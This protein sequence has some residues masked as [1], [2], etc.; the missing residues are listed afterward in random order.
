MENNREEVH[1]LQ[2]ETAKI[3]NF[4]RQKIG[5]LVL[6]QIGEH[7]LITQLYVTIFLKL[8]TTKTFG[9]AMKV[10]ESLTVLLT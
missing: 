5:L 2:L 9:K 4:Y 6:Y 1:N 8:L 3:K 7:T 10:M